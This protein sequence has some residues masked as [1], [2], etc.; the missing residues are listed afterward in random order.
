MRIV[1]VGPKGAGKTSVARALAELAGLERVGT[2][3][4]IEALHQERGGG[5]LSCREI[6]KQ[7]GEKAFRQ[8]EVEAV[9]RIADHDWR[10]FDTGGST[11]LD[12]ASRRRLR[13]DSIVVFLT[14]SSDRLWHAPARFPLE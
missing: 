2:D 7:Q 3:E 1:I 8:L 10:V 5:A 11:M 12:S 13:R 6:F 9:R 14:A 4:E